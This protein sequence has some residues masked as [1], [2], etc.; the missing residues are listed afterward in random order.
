MKNAQHSSVASH[1]VAG[2][3]PCM[4]ALR[5]DTIHGV[6]P[7]MAT[8]IAHFSAFALQ[9]HASYLYEHRLPLFVYRIILEADI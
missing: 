5:R 6:R 9:S 3:P 1:E 8:F 2:R 4:A 7:Y